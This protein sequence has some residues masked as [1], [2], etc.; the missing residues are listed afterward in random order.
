MF[1]GRI[2]VLHEVI[3]VQGSESQY[4]RFANWHLN[5]A[6][7]WIGTS[8]T[9]ATQEVGLNPATGVT[10]LIPLAIQE[11]AQL[12]ESARRLSPNK[13]DAEQREFQFGIVCVLGGQDIMLPFCGRPSFIT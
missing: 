4:V 8:A 7:V 11:L 5:G 9:N 1:I 2:L 13:L 3:P 6:K 10:G 12:T